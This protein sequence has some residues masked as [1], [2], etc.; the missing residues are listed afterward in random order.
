MKETFRGLCMSIFI[1]EGDHHNHQPLF[2]EIVSKAHKSGLSGATV[3]RGF[4]GFGVKHRIH[5]TRILAL[6][7]ALPV[8]VVIVD[9]KEKIEQ[10]KE[11][12]DE[13][14]VEGMVT[15]QEVEISHYK[16]Q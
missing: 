7:R 8:V 13:L 3:L 5:T 10:F 11:I 1:T 15:L 16:K 9:T 4:E 12:V 14:L 2:V 6:D